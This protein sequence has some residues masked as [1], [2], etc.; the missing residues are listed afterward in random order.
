[1]KSDPPAF[2]RKDKKCLKETEHRSLRWGGG[3]G[4][5]GRAMNLAD[6]NGF[7][8]LLIVLREN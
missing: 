2:K 5:G 8:P 3:G 4:G 1:M 6:Y 7:C